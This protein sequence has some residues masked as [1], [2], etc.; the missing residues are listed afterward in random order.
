MLRTDRY[1]GVHLITNYDKVIQ[2]HHE[3]EQDVP[4]LHAVDGDAITVNNFRSGYDES[5]D[6]KVRMKR[7]TIDAAQ[8]KDV[9]VGIEPFEPEIIAAHGLLIFT[10]HTDRSVT[11]AD[12]FKDF[13]FAL[14]VESRREVDEVHY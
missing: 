11:A 5:D 6:F 2:S 4:T 10:M 13:G 7:V 14:S 8:I 9:Y 3:W 12:G 1:G